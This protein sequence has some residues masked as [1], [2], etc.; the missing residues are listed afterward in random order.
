M[1]SCYGI[2]N[3]F[4]LV[5][6]RPT[7]SGAV[8]VVPMCTCWLE[9]HEVE[10]E[11]CPTR[12]WT[13][14]HIDLALVRVWLMLLRVIPEIAVLCHPLCLRSDTLEQPLV[15]QTGVPEAILS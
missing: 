14:L 9:R 1:D 7:V 15:A 5:V 2:D 10:L 4:V 12:E 11:G 13:S 8:L 3:V 6:V